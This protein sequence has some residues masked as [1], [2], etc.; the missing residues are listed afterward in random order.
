[1]M[2]NSTIPQAFQENMHVRNGV[3]SPIQCLLCNM[4]SKKTISSVRRPHY[5]QY[6]EFLIGK[7]NCHID[8]WI[9]GEEMSLNE[10]DLL[11]INADIPHSFDHSKQTGSYICIKVLPKMIYFSENPMYDSKYVVPFLQNNLLPYQF[12]KR[13]ELEGS[14]V[15]KIMQSM[16]D[17]WAA[18]EYGY[19]IA[20]KSL[21]LQVFLW[22]IRYNHEK[23]RSLMEPSSEVSY[24]NIRLIQKSVEFINKSFAEITESDAAAKVNMSYSYY[25]KLFRRV[26]GKNFNDYLTTV[27]INEAERLLLSSDLSVTEIALATG[28]STSSHFIEKFRKLKKITPKQY[29]L[30]WKK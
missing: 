1:M 15:S 14:N 16:L 10:G 4:P 30:T 7:K 28:F 23:G 12:F 19:E 21:F 5:H 11:V 17:C 22:I 6:I 8:T 29:R 20:I 25:S 24:E 26:M 13:K 2:Q 9:A 3:E 27:R 18:Q